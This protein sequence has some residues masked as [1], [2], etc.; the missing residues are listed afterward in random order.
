M[1]DT[2][3]DF[4][5]DTK[6]YWEGFWSRR[7]GLG[8]GKYDPDTY[9]RTLRK[10]HSLLWSRETPSGVVLDLQETSLSKYLTW[11]DK[12]FGSDSI[13]TGFRYKKC[14]ELL[15]TVPNYRQVMEDFIHK[16]YIIGGMI[17]FP[18][19]IWSMNQARGVN[20]KIRD[21]WDLTLEC[22]RRYYSDEDSPLYETCLRDKEFYDLF[23]DFKGY[24]DFFYLQD[25][26]SS[27]YKKVNLWLDTELFLYNPFPKNA[28][29]YMEF[30]NA[31]LDY[32][33]KR[34]SRI[35][36]AVN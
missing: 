17:I 1:I 4:T 10:Y 6:D 3:F 27:D 35:D 19:H 9:S 13:T 25:M 32:V 15:E 24:V 30:I 12:C 33:E 26:V 20:A 8:A 11:N 34:N 5:L 36:T 18:K 23:V 2:T 16:N 21:R 28:K 31:E 22:I 14:R 29:V 7:G